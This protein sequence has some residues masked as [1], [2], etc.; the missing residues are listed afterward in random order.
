MFFFPVRCICGICF[1]FCTIYF[2][3]ELRQVLQGQ[4]SPLHHLEREECTTDSKWKEAHP[5]QTSTQKPGSCRQGQAADGSWA[6][7]QQTD[8]QTGSMPTQTIS[9]EKPR[10]GEEHGTQKQKLL[11]HETTPLS[12]Y[13]WLS[14]N[15]QLNQKARILYLLLLAV[16]I[17][18][19]Q[20][21]AFQLLSSYFSSVHSSLWQTELAGRCT[22]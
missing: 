17:S 6:A 9:D 11:S 7:A 19:W 5:E 3:T 4:I 18:C 8:R 13:L 20:A 12:V 1:Q 22:C 15:T 2:H 16:L 10:S 14:E 21:H